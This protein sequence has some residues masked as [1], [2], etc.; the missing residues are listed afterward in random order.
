M[1]NSMKN[2]SNNYIDLETKQLSLLIGLSVS[3][4]TVKKYHVY[5]V[6]LV[7]HTF[8][9]KLGSLR[10]PCA[11]HVNLSVYTFMLYITFCL[12]HLKVTIWAKLY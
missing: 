11:Y 6:P 12:W 8:C 10:Q 9:G 7:L 4:L 2:E 3:P 5:V 1:Y